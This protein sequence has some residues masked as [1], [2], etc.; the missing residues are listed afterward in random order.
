MT[1]D[2]RGGE[3]SIHKCDWCQ[4]GYLVV[5]Q[6][7]YEGFFLGCTNYKPD[8]TGCGRMLSAGQYEF[9]LNNSFGVEDSS[10]YKPSYFVPKNITAVPKMQRS[11]TASG[12]NG[13][14]TINT[15]AYKEIVI[16]NEVFRIVVDSEGNTLT[17]MDLLSM[18]RTMRARVA[19]EKEL[20]SYYLLH[21]NILVLIATDKPT[22]REELMGISGFGIRKW[23]VWG[24]EIVKM[25]TKYMSGH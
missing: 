15:T 23:E 19:R 8:R 22:T 25:V 11:K 21:N 9:W 2:K 16:E 6:S 3:L 14:T 12:R 4:D 5:K 7:K 18:L 24:D 17:D 10:Q 13:G 1:N 20:S